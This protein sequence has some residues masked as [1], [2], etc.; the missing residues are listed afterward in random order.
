MVAEVTEWNLNLVDSSYEHAI[1]EG[2]CLSI[3]KIV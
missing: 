3:N 1:N 2:K